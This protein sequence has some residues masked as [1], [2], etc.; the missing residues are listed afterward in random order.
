MY[1]VPQDVVMENRILYVIMLTISGLPGI[2]LKSKY[3]MTVILK[4]FQNLCITISY[5][6]PKQVQ[7]DNAWF[8]QQPVII[9]HNYCLYYLVC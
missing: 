5:D 8:G 9:R 7:G 2:L 3:L 4:L 1:S 6:T